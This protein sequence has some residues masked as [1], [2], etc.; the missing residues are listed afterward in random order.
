MNFDH[1]KGWIAERIKQLTGIFTIDVAAWS[2]M[3]QIS[4]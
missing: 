4:I 3:T 1:P 2:G